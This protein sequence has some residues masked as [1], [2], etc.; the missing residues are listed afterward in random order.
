M[1]IKR[2]VNPQITM[3]LDTINKKMI[4]L[5]HPALEVLTP[6]HPENITR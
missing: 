5:K 6:E 1:A 2:T 3:L 4:E